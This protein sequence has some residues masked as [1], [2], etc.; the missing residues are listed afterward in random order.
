MHPRFRPVG[1]GLASL[2]VLL[3]LDA[4][5]A[6]AGDAALAV[7]FTRSPRGHVLV[8]VTLSDGVPRSFVLDTAAGSC[9]I[10]PEV[11]RALGGAPRGGR[12]TVVGEAGRREQDVVTLERVTFGG[13]SLDGVPA[14]VQDLSGI[15]AGAFAFDGILGAPFLRPFDVRIDFAND[16]VTLFAPG[17]GAECPVC[18]PASSGVAI[19]IREQGHVLLP[20]SVAGVNVTALLDTGAGH[21]GIN[22]LAAKAL[23]VELPDVP[24]NGHGLGILA[25]PIRVGERTLQEQAPLRVM[26]REDI[27]APLG[28]ADRPRLLLGTDL[29]AG[30]VLSI[31]YGTGRLFLE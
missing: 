9:V 4:P 2:A 28:L 30:R 17:A 10:S 6:G 23:G 21:S 11:A 31:S 16:R 15:S 14:I 13:R 12:A 8:P 29:L 20:A 19:E 18:P 24:A 27:F 3:A 25:G 26:D 1:Q 5:A 7:P 22:S